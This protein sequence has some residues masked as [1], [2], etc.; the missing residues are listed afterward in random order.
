MYIECLYCK[1]VCY[2]LGEILWEHLVFSFR[3]YYWKVHFSLRVLKFFAFYFLRLFSL[4]EHGQVF[5]LFTAMCR[6]YRVAD[7]ICIYSVWLLLV[8]TCLGS[9]YSTRRIT[10]FVVHIRLPWNF[11][12][13]H[14]NKRNCLSFKFQ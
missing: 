4:I 2:E 10:V 13:I 14:R 12:K 9:T 7:Y 3:N 1:H 6:V 11:I 8:Y 5:L